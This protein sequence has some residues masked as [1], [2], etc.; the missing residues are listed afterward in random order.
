MRDAATELNRG[1]GG[2]KSSAEHASEME[3]RNPG[4]QLWFAAFGGPPKLQKSA[5]LKLFNSSS[6]N[7]ESG[8]VSLRRN[9][10]GVAY[11]LS[12]I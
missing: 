7:Q 1:A 2:F 9:R 3:P 10:A 6:N 4:G 11:A 12:G 8:I 5:K